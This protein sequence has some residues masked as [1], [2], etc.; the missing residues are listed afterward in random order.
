MTVTDSVIDGALGR[1][2]EAMD[3]SNV[4]IDRSVVVGQV[5]STRAATAVTLT[6][7]LAVMPNPAFAIVIAGGARAAVSGST[8]RQQSVDRPVALVTDPQ[9]RIDVVAS[10][11]D[12]GNAGIEVELSGIALLARSVVTVPDAM[13]IDGASIRLSPAAVANCT[14]SGCDPR[15]SAVQGMPA[16]A[17]VPVAVPIDSTDARFA[18]VPASVDFVA[19]PSGP[20]LAVRDLDG[21]C[22]QDGGPP[23]ALYTP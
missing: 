22:R 4:V 5:I 6:S 3:F 17:L 13:I 16:N 14:T 23:G 11:L 2:Y 9:S 1:A 10:V 8:V 7:S 12:G 20:T 15:S 19:A 21:V 18:T